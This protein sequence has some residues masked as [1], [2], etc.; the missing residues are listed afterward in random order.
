M[1]E[2][3]SPHRKTETD[4]LLYKLHEPTRA[5]TPSSLDERR[6][7]R[8]PQD[9]AAQQTLRALFWEDPLKPNKSFGVIYSKCLVSF[10]R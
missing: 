8:L 4:K 9:A 3:A 10:L 6:N 5:E 7:A 2:R 1:S